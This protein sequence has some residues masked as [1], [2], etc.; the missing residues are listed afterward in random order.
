M[1][2]DHGSQGA[3]DGHSHDSGQEEWVLLAWLSAS[4]LLF[5]LLGL[6]SDYFRAAEWVSITLYLMAYLCGGWD[7]AVDASERVRRGVLDI[8]FLMLSVAIGA[9]LIGAWREGA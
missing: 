6:L 5:M 1:S 3:H 2:H 7:A 9:A 8:H 4:C